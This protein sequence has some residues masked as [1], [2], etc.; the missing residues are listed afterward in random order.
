MMKKSTVLY[1]FLF[2]FLFVGWGITPAQAHIEEPCPHK[3][4]H[5]HCQEGSGGDGGGAIMVHGGSFGVAASEL[6]VVGTG[7]F[8]VAYR[9]P[10]DGT[11]QN[12]RIFIGENTS[13]GPLDAII[14][15]NGSPTSLSATIP[16]ESTAVIDVND[17]VDVLDGDVIEV[18]LDATGSSG[19]SV[20]LSVSY[21]IL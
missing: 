8:P 9:I 3:E 10:R 20:K 13:V 5:Q 18:F 17:M 1:A 15:V 19:G 11:I 16:A 21:E 7:S 12:M 4:G 2:F 14:F 6:F